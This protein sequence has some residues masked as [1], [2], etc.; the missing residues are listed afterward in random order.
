MKIANVEVKMVA[1][2]AVRSVPP[3]RRNYGNEFDMYAAWFLDFTKDLLGSPKAFKVL[4]DFASV[5][6]FSH[7]REKTKKTMKKSGGP[8]RPSSPTSIV[9]KKTLFY[10][11]ALAA[12]PGL[13]HHSD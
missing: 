5:D 11:S 7:V 1:D 10:I 6:A 12:A 4:D 13:R 2:Y 9:V 3:V 8:T